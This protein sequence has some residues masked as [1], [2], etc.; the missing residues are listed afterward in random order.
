[1]RWPHLTVVRTSGNAGHW[2]QALPEGVIYMPKPWQAD[3]VLALAERA[4]SGSV[5]SE[6]TVNC[7]VDDSR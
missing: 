3:E 2:L 6:L 4:R 7:L 1:M 5:T